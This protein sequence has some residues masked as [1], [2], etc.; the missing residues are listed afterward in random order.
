M[1]TFR[2]VGG[3]ALFVLIIGAGC[4][5]QISI[6]QECRSQHSFMYCWHVLGSK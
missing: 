3:L 6:W 5:Y 2:V 1:K 4:A